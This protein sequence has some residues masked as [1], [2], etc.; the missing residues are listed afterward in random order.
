[1]SKNNT[2]K[3]STSSS[4]K[5]QN[6]AMGSSLSPEVSNIFTQ[7][8]EKLALN[9]QQQNY[10]YGSNYSLQEFLNHIHSLRPAIKFTTEV[11]TDSVIPLLDML[12]INKGS[13]MD[14]KVYRKHTHT[15][16]SYHLQLNCLSR[17]KRGVVQNPY[18]RATTIWQNQ[19]DR[20]D[21][22][23]IVRYDLQL[24]AYPIGFIDSVIKKSKRN[25]HLW[26]V[27]QTLDF[28]SIK[29]ITDV[30]KKF[31]HIA[32]RYNIITVSS[33]RHTLKNSLMTMGPIRA[34][35]ENG[36]CIYSIPCECGRSYIGETGR[37]W[38]VRFREHRRNLE[39]HLERSRYAQ[40]SFEENCQM[41]WKEAK[42][43]EI[44]TNS[45]YRKYKEVAYMSCLQNPI[46]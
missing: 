27:V 33:M 35:Q 17:L 45:I 46:T 37:P 28:I 1:V 16:H 3:L 26:K 20:S 8:F 2:F 25:V 41:I 7:Y 21:K 5:K 38:A 22:I 4:N 13:T 14:T 24:S 6:M 23:Y 30:S 32:N 15:G 29:Y 43:L 19:Q 40:H 11:E 36:N 9:T 10:H 44:E 42:I 12:V 34:L 39:V 31:K 18:H